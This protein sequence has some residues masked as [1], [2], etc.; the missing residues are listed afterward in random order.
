MPIQTQRGG[1]GKLPNHSNSGTKNRLMVSIT[2]LPFYPSEQ[3]GIF[4]TGDLMVLGADLGDRI[5]LSPIRI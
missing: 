1:G 2:L 4:C 3:L 5:D